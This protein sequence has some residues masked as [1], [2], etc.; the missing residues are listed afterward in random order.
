MTR[1]EAKQ[2]LP[3]IQA[4]ADGKTIQYLDKDFNW[5][6]FDDQSFS[7]GFSYRIKSEINIDHSRTKNSVVRE[8]KIN[9]Q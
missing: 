5:Q 6:D 3:I 2:L 7:G 8:K 4:Y 1:E 9:W